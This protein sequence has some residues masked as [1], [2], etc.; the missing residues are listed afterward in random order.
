MAFFAAPLAGTVQSG[1]VVTI[2]HVV[3]ARIALDEGHG[4][5]EDMPLQHIA[6]DEAH[7]MEIAREAFVELVCM[8]PP[9]SAAV[10]IAC[11]AV[12]SQH[13]HL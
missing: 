11:S 8:M 9:A 5:E 6:L 4:I 12:G 13:L 10:E 3:E 7:L 1:N 2:S